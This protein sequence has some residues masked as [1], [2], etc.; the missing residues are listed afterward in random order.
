MPKVAEEN[1]LTI[2]ETRRKTFPRLTILQLI[3]HHCMHE[4][5]IHVGQGSM[6]FNY[7]GLSTLHKCFSSFFRIAEITIGPMP[8]FHLARREKS[9][10]AQRETVN[11]LKIHFCVFRG[12][13]EDKCCCKSCRPFKEDTFVHLEHLSILNGS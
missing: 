2:V 3:L 9:G 5:Q 4:V 8:K 13:V 7:Q 10:G 11:T 12:R 1:R 6:N